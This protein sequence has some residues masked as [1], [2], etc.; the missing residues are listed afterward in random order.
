MASLRALPLHVLDEIARHHC[1]VYFGIVSTVKRYA[2]SVDCAAMRRYFF[3]K[4]LRSARNIAEDLVRDEP[5]C[6]GD[7]ETNLECFLSID[8]SFGGDQGGY[9]GGWL[10][11]V[12]DDEQEP[13]FV[14]HF[15]GSQGM[16]P[17][18]RQAL[19]YCSPRVPAITALYLFSDHCAAT[20]Q[21]ADGTYFVYLPVDFGRAMYSF[22]G[23]DL[24]EVLDVA[25]EYTHY[26]DAKD[27]AASQSELW[28][29]RSAVIRGETSY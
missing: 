17:A 9:E 19:V 22:M 13:E 12:G 25:I 27:L 23:D 5:D 21:L 1:S 26:R 6:A 3:N 10:W 11:W 14:R 4:G 29:W 28:A 20:G 18:Y 16:Y 2:D 8:G 15:L 7:E 24:L